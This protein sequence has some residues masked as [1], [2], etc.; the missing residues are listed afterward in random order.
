MEH[1]KKKVEQVIEDFFKGKESKLG[2]ELFNNWYLDKASSH[3]EIPDKE[4]IKNEI[5]AAVNKRITEGRL[6]LGSDYGRKKAYFP[7]FKIAASIAVV[8]G[9]TYAIYG[10]WKSVENLSEITVSKVE[11]LNSRGERSTFR[12]PDGTIVKLNSQSK[13]T[14]T[15]GFDIDKREVYLEGE[16]FFDVVK[17]R[18]RPFKVHSGDVVTTA[19]GTS[20][21]VKSFSNGNGESKVSVSLVTGKV[22][23][24]N[25]NADVDMILSPG[26]Q[27]VVGSFEPIQ[28]IFQPN[29]VLAWR[30]GKIL[31]NDTEF[32]EI[33]QVLEGWYDVDFEVSGLSAKQSHE[34]K[35]TGKFN[36]QKETLKTVLEVL[37]HSMNFKYSLNKSKVNINF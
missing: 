19:L 26:E 27:A 29:A 18:S 16:A 35:G 10:Q 13:L 17:D 24:Q 23:V 30:N 21:N 28:R 22:S 3:E 2:R 20:F 7:F 4:V 36:G 9:L 25:F 33:V 12:L 32:V 8:I 31:F 14:F 1:S 6:I 15:Q 34:L 37:S 11:K 5:Y